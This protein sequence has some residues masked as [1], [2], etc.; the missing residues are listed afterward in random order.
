M[1][2]ISSEISRAKI[3]LPA[4]LL[5]VAL[6]GESLSAKSQQK[7]P[8]RATSSPSELSDAGNGTETT[9]EIAGDSMFV[10]QRYQEAIEDYEK[11]PEDSVAVWNKKGIAY[12]MLLDL[13]DA[14]RCFKKALRLN[15]HDARPW[16]NLGSVYDAM[17]DQ[18]RAEHQY[19]K[20]LKLNPNY[21][22][23][24]RN[25]GTNLIFQGEYGE[26]QELYKRALALNR[27][28]LG[29]D[30][31]DIATTNIVSA[32]KL[33]AMNYYKARNYAQAGM[34]AQAI[35][36]LRRALDEGF[37]TPEK[38]TGDR[39]FI[40]IRNDPAFRQLIGQHQRQ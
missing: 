13:K 3:L 12:E 4:V 6:C 17:N 18:P 21:A 10:Q 29:D 35:K 24:L 9:A 1:W 20:A 8:D 26:G 36:S 32:N 38:I 31:D 15:P 7:S 27:N 33:G 16:N 25:L 40:P 37:T 5:I 19:R 23:A 28:I 11:A 39:S 30:G 22:T 34:S 14:E 2:R